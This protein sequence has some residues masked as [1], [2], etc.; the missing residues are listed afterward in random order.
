MNKLNRVFRWSI[1]I[2]KFSPKMRLIKWT[3]DSMDRHKLACLVRRISYSL[4]NSSDS[5]VVWKYASSKLSA[6]FHQHDMSTWQA[7]ISSNTE[8][9]QFRNVNVPL[10]LVTLFT[11]L[12][13]KIFCTWKRKVKTWRIELDPRPDIPAAVL[14]RR[15]AAAAVRDGLDPIRQC[16][17]HVAPQRRLLR[18]EPFHLHEYTFMHRRISISITINSLIWSN[19]R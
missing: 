19:W 16:Q 8:D 7:Q 14:I 9:N 3:F 15:A 4:L 13:K 1:L 17:D 5:S 2:C 18:R 12:Q 11:V 6:K 10:I